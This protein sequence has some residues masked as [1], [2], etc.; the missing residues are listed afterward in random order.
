M[1]LACGTFVSIVESG[2][3]VDLFIP[4]FIHYLSSFLASKEAAIL[5]RERGEL[6]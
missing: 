1:H 3:I 4:P 5:G 6:I 2:S